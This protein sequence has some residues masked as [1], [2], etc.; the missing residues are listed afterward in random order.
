MV[1]GF[2]GDGPETDVEG[3]VDVAD[4]GELVHRGS[5]EGQLVVFDRFY[6]EVVDRVFALGEYEVPELV[7]GHLPF[8][9]F[10]VDLPFLC[11]LGENCP[12]FDLHHFVFT[13]FDLVY[14]PELVGRLFELVGLEF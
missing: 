13:V 14:D 4:L 10:G 3:G 11:L 7:V 1:V 9:N 6:P 12:C 8:G 2:G 5:A